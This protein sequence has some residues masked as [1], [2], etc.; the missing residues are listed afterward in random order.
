MLE[1]LYLRLKEFLD[2]RLFRPPVLT[3]ISIYDRKKWSND[4]RAGINVALLAIP[5]GMAYALVAG[6]PISYG[7]FGS[8]VAAIMG[9]LYGGGRFITLGPTNATA[10][11]LFGVFA[12]M[13]LVKANGMGTTEALS[14]LPWILI[15]SGVFLIF[16]SLLRVSFMIQFISLGP[17]LQPM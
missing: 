10:V 6:L 12:G 1:N 11:L 2:L 9:G 14:M 3:E 16:A 7:L 13:G 8:A 4:W 15:V 17:S 5:Q